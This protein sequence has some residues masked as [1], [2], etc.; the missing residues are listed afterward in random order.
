M[1]FT[2]ANHK[3]GGRSNQGAEVRSN[4]LDI[5]EG[6]IVLPEAVQYEGCLIFLYRQLRLAILVDPGMPTTPPGV[7]GAVLV[8]HIA[9]IGQHRIADIIE[10]ARNLRIASMAQSV[11]H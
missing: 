11:C 4:K 10:T 8:Q 7:V 1:R 6:V 5:V 9:S 3:I 2:I